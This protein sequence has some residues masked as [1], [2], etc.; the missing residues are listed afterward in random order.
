MPKLKRRQKLKREY[1]AMEKRCF[2][3]GIVLTCYFS[4]PHKNHVPI[5]EFKAAWND[6]RDELLPQWIAEHP[7][8]R[9]IGWLRFDVTEPRLPVEG[10]QL[11]DALEWTRANCHYRQHYFFGIN[12]RLGITDDSHSSEAPF[13]SEKQYLIRIGALTAEELALL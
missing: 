8:T 12:R 10:E 5:E 7:F 9:P 3:D 4:H 13:E 1:D 6:L 11:R 2:T